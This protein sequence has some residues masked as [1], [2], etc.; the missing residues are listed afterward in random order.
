MLDNIYS[1]AILRLA[2]NIT[3]IGLL[4]NA[5]AYSSRQS[6]ICGSKITVSIKLDDYLIS[7]F[8]QELSACALGQASAALLAKYVIGCSEGD[9]RFLLQQ[10]AH[11]LRT[12][13]AA[14]WGRFPEFALLQPACEYKARH[15]ALMLP[16]LACLDCFV[17][18]NSSKPQH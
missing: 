16:L 11:M 3:H 10:L 8:G 14:N 7:A 5:D 15:G 6:K 9:I 1:P 2:A 4:D 18:I 13:S 17:K 12:N